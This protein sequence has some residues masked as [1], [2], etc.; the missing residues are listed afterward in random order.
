MKQF[1]HVV[2]STGD[3]RLGRIRSVVADVLEDPATLGGAHA[4]GPQAFAQI[5]QHTDAILEKL[6]V[7]VV[8]DAGQVG[9]ILLV[10]GCGAAL[11]TL[12]ALLFVLLWLM[13]LLLGGQLLLPDE[14]SPCV[15]KGPGVKK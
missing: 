4:L 5:P 13:V 15:A 12:M 2:L 7:H 8:S 11:I 10:V 1:G 3:V 9:R 6:R 14:I